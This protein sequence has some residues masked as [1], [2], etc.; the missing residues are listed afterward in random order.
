MGQKLFAGPHGDFQQ[1]C[2]GPA[3]VADIDI[4]LH[5]RV[6]LQIHGVGPAKEQGQEVV[7]R[8]GEAATLTI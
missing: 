5:V 3:L 4:L 8:Q 2:K 6:F 1:V 7:L